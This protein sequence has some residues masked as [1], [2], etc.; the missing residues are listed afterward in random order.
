MKEMSHTF[1][2]WEK[3][4]GGV[5]GKGKG[6]SQTISSLI[7]VLSASVSLGVCSLVGVRKFGTDPKLV[8]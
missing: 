3:R 7:R 6:E 4:V 1:L 8:K 5:E 2:L